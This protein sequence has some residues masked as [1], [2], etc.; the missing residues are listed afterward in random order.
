MNEFSFFPKGILQIKPEKNIDLRLCS[1]YIHTQ[2]VEKTAELR[3][4]TDQKEQQEFKKTFPYVTFGGTFTSR[5][6]DKL[7]D[8]SGYLCIDLD[9]IEDIPAVKDQILK[10]YVPALMFISPSGNGLKVVFSVD[11]KQ[12]THL[13]YFLAL[14][15]FFKTIFSLSIDQAC[16]DVARACFLC[17]D[18]DVYYSDSPSLLNNDLIQLTANTNQESLPIKDESAIYEVAKKWTD[19]RMTFTEGNRNQYITMLAGACNRMGISEQYASNQMEG[20]ASEGFTIQEIQATIK[21]TYRNT[22]YHGT[23]PIAERKETPKEIVQ[24]TDKPILSPKEEDIA[25]PYIR[26]GTDYFKI[27]MKKDRYGIERRDLKRWTKDALITDHK[28]SFLK[29]I[30]KYDDF[31]MVPD[32]I[33][34]QEIINNCYNMY[35]PFCHTPAPGEW[36]WTE[37]LMRQVFGEQYELGIRYMQLLYCYPHRSTVILVLVSSKQK[38]GKTTFVNWINMVF[39]SNTA[40]I[41]SLD[42][43]SA[44]NGHYATKNIVMIEETLFDKKITIERLKALATSKML[45]INRKNIDQFNLEFFGK[46]ILTS[47]YEDK[48]ASVNPEET[49]FFV[50]KLGD[51]QFK[52]T[53]IENNLLSEVPAFLYY[54]KSLPELSDSIDRSGF[55][56][57]ELRNEFLDAVK[58]ESKYETSKELKIQITDYFNE[59]ENLKCFYASASNLKDKFFYSDNRTG[60]AWLL[61]VLKDDFRMEPEGASRYTPFEDQTI[62]SKTGRPYLFKREDFTRD[63][64]PLK[65]KQNEDEVDLPF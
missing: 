44:F 49:R 62:G 30:P 55:T 43:Q 38:T 52:N 39:G 17:N 8:H 29:T 31:V 58:E 51:P 4:L 36:I 9:H 10:H 41:S 48:F 20:F 63:K 24:K 50:R 37:R 59:H 64:L 28:R 6:N 53:S 25:N 57:E 40:V 3:R 47:N 34:Y 32:N 27:I 42:F 16:K 1:A 45:S 33:S 22:Q 11:I 60:R 35:A 26:V 14:Q 46:I 65:D 15:S 61:R 2:L 56:A 23:A 21:S 12:G 7:I 19:R 13:Q 5:A 18:P 54:L